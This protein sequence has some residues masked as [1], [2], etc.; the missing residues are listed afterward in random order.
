VTA[1]LSEISD[2]LLNASAVELKNE[3]AMDLWPEDWEFWFG[4]PVDIAREL[5][6]PELI[7]ERRIADLSGE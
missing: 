3:T 7:Q 6:D 2:A 1:V 4:V 5:L